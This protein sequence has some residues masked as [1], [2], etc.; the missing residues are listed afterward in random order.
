MKHYLIPTRPIEDGLDR[1]NLSILRKRFLAVNGDR[2]E[3]MRQALAPRHRLILNALPIIFHTN[4]PM[5]PGFTNRRTPCKI[6]GFKPEKQDLEYG[7]SI[8]RSFTINYEP[9]I[10]EDIYGIYV[11]G[12]VGTVAQSD[13]SDLDIWICHRPDISLDRL[14]QLQHKCEKI[15]E[16]ADSQRL[17]A[18][19]F[20]MN[21]D[22]FKRG[23]LSS[24]GQESSGSAQR[25]LLLDEFY[26]SAIYLAGRTPL[27]W[28]VPQH[29][30][31]DYPQY[32]DTLLSKRFLQPDH[33]IDFGGL[34][35]IPGGEFIGA[36]IWQLY[37]AIESPYKSVL[38]LLLLEAYVNDFPNI[39]PL[40]LT[41]KKSIYDGTMDIDQLDS[42][43]MIYL[44]IEQY[45]T[46]KQQFKRL[47]LARR[48]FYFKVHRR[49]TKSTRSSHRPWQREILQKFVDA[50]GWSQDELEHLDSR[51]QWKAYAVNSE[52]VQLVNELNHSYQF[53]LE[54]AQNDITERSISG[55][56]LTVL[57]RKLQAAFERRPG[58]ID[59]INPNIS[60]DLS[61]DNL[62][63]EPY[64][65]PET[66]RPLWR[67]APGNNHKLTLKSCSNIC[68]LI[69]W[70]FFNGVISAETPLDVPQGISKTELRRLLNVLDQWIP[71]NRGSSAHENFLSAAKPTHVLILIN[72]GASASPKLQ[73]Q[74]LQ[75]LSN[76]TD[77][78]RYGGHSENLIA[79]VDLISRNSWHEI[80]A[81]HF[82]DD[83]ALL[84]VLEEF[85]QLC[86][87]GTHQA[88]P[89]L[90]IECIG[91]EHA[92][93][94][95]HRVRELFT[96][97]GQCFYGKQ[98][99]HTRYLFQLAERFYCLQFKG[100]RPTL[101]AY[102]NEDALIDSLEGAQAQFSPIVIDKRALRDTPLPLISNKM[103]EGSVNIFY[104]RFDIGMETYI[105]DEK[106]S[107][108][109]EKF[110]GLMNY[111][112][113][114]P[115]HRFIRA[116]INRQARTNPE[117]TSDFGIRPI[118]FFE[119]VSRPREAIHAVQK[120]IPQKSVNN[121]LFD[122]RAVAH[123]DGDRRLLYDFVC[124][125]QEFSSET[126]GEQLFLVVA[127]F[128]LS[129][130]QAD[131]TYP[132][133]LTDLDLSLATKALSPDR[134][135]QITDYLRIKNFLEFK[136][137]Q[138]IGILMKA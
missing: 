136:L 120:Q 17:E 22:A 40:S 72:V 107:L 132:I 81:R 45:L 121:L 74:G 93:T 96:E 63:I 108:T 27:W 13:S 116:A 66:D 8:A 49:L 100:M 73:N 65:D 7:R 54:F 35:D 109:Y 97:I 111:N 10:E 26:R 43:A 75:R 125:D 99:A 70:N 42:Y 20:L 119:L 55:E 124:D 83:N 130:R 110:R 101:K 33:V 127:Q 87:P 133:Y 134:P 103:S 137:N 19:F 25:L 11:M 64:L 122:V 37:K 38:K 1:Q 5:M 24:L 113:L 56:E 18:H 112:P 31:A 85:L 9:D 118:Y 68:E 23:E 39:T 117:I 57:G 115:L 58:K 60:D 44:R 12:S 86:L 34:A 79:S 82:E 90:R 98:A 67:S 29:N 30:E 61:E 71:K 80:H 88:P 21:A 106:G 32:T 59:W 135:L 84:S 47:E 128:V 69:I 50:W 92:S 95:A 41:Y 53:L 4:H 102:T 126:F 131:E 2:L 28:F 52:R 46:E 114:V 89:E 94:I 48:C 123:T 91:A 6:S 105:V 104:R 77:A 14:E 15:T 129:R 78:L 36:G 62:F 76:N 3:R 16:W 138:A 51:A